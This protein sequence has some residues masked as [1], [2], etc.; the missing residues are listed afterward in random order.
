MAD[1]TLSL[2]TIG[3]RWLGRKVNRTTDLG[4]DDGVCQSQLIEID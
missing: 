2:L 1:A 3:S 4:T